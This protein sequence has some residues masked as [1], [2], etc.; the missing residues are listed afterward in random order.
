MLNKV[1]FYAAI[2][3]SIFAG[4]LTEGQVQGMEVII[5]K[6]LSD[7]V[8]WTDPR[9]LAY[10]LAT[11]H[12]ETAFTMQPVRET[13]APTDDRAIAILEK[14][15]AKG[16]MPWVKRAYWRKD[17]QGRSWLGRGLVQ[18]TFEENYARL[19]PWAGTD[20]VRK[21]DMA[22]DPDAA[23]NIMFE[24]MSRGLFRNKKLSDYF[25]GTKNLAVS[26]RQ[27]INPDDKGDEIAAVH[28]KFLKA[29]K[30]AGI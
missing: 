7:P 5:D 9:W 24:G 2:K 14:S 4:R 21:P 20:L 6:W 13:L 17:D 25:D 16:R 26:A 29:L 12:H 23:V 1:R 10:M 28:L 3:P 15:W 18:L 30:E 8:R 22:M 27:V 19:S 11:A